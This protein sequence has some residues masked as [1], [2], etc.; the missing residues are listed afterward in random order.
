MSKMTLWKTHWI[1]LICGLVGIFY[2]IISPAGQ[3]YGLILGVISILLGGVG[4][5]V[6]EQ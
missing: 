2:H 6:G 5:S 4:I 1:V 3:Q